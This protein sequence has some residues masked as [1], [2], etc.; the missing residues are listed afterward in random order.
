MSQ[1]AQSAEAELKAACW[2]CSEVAC[3]D[4]EG[5]PFWLVLAQRGGQRVVGKSATREDAWR[6]AA[7][8]AQAL[9][10]TGA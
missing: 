6:I 8:K 7:D 4:A 2:W 3:Q 10:E 5:S 9:Q 1:L